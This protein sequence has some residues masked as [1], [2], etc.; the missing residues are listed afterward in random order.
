MTTVRLLSCES[1][2]KDRKDN[3]HNRHGD[4]IE[5]KQNV[6]A[7]ILYSAFQEE[8][9]VLSF[10]SHVTQAF[11]RTACGIVVQTG[12]LALAIISVA[13]GILR[14]YSCPCEPAVPVFL[15]VV[16]C[17]GILKAIFVGIEICTRS[18]HPDDSEPQAAQTVNG[19]LTLFLVF[20]TVTGSVWVYGIWT[21]VQYGSEDLPRYCDKVLYVYSFALLSTMLLYFILKLITTLSL[22]VIFHRWE[23]SIDYEAM[24]RDAGKH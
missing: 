12:G 21:K 14:Y 16:G 11:A 8:E 18:R 13:I 3:H 19:I 1:R 6:I 20:W 2:P 22:C 7:N 15:L 4:P 17:V 23:R 10:A 5:Y 9:D 24:E